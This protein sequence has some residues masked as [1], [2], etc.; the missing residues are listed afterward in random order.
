MDLDRKALALA[1]VVSTLIASVAW[2]VVRLSRP[3]TIDVRGSAKRRITSDL[4]E[5]SAQISVTRKDR[6]E[7]YT[8]LKKD[9]EA[10]SAFLEG[11]GFPRDQVRISAANTTQL[12][13][14]DT[15]EEN[16]RVTR[17]TVFD[18][19]QA[20]QTVSV[21]SKEVQRVEK[22][23]REATQLLEKGVDITSQSP[24]YLFTGVGPLKIEMLAEASR[25]ARQRAERM[26]EA[27]GGGAKVGQVVGVDTGVIN[28][29]AANSTET[30][31]EGNFDTSSYE[32]D[33]LTTVRVRFEVKN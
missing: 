24:S 4:A 12:S 25:D 31:W 26:I 18:G 10:L 33:I 30:S 2:S 3:T 13:H 28:I 17:R 29:N 21:V 5:W 1:L 32:K 20:T 19:W 14:E 7:A 11:A 15:V 16:N 27:A 9:V 6:V 8:A 22:V 23:S